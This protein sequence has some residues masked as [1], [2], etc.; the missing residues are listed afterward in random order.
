MVHDRK[1]GP[2]TSYEERKV[3]RT[4]VVYIRKMREQEA[5]MQELREIRK[6]KEK[7]L[8]KNIVDSVGPRWYQALSVPQRTALDT[9]ATAI[10]QDTL[11]GRPIRT[12][13]VMVALGLYPRPN[14]TDLMNC[15]YLGRDDPKE[16]LA[17]LFLMTYGHTID[18][19]QSLYCLNARLMLSGIFYLGLE[20]LLHLLRERF[21]A[22]P[23]KKELIRKPKSKPEPQ[24]ASPYL[25]KM[26]A[27]LYKPP[28][29]KRFQP[30][31]LPNLDDLNEPYEEEP[32]LAKPPP[33]PPP[34]PPPKKR[35]PRAYC[36]K[37]AGV[38]Q[39]D[40]H[41]SA[42]AIAK[43]SPRNSKKSRSSKKYSTVDKKGGAGGSTAQKTGR[44]KKLKAPTTGMWN[45]QYQISGVYKVRGKTVFVLGN[46]SILPPLG[47]L[48]HGGYKYMGGQCINVHCGFRGRP[49][50]PKPDP[51]DCVTKWTD[52]VFQYVKSTKCYCG[53]NFDYG[54]EGTFLPDELP[55][56]LKP[57]RNT[58]ALFNY[59]TIYEL[60]QKSLQIAKEFKALWDTDSVLHVDDG[61]DKKDKKKKKKRS[62]TTCLGQKPKP[63]DYLKCA[64]R[65]MRRV[66]IAARLPDLYLAPELKE[67]MRRRIYGPFSDR[68][69]MKLLN[70]SKMCWNYLQVLSNRGFGHVYPP[71]EPQ[72]AGHTTWVHKQRLNDKFRKYTFNYRLEMYRSH[73]KITNMMW[74]SM[75]QSQF[76]DKKFREIYF[77]YLFAKIED[78]QLMHPYTM[79]E[80]MD[81]ACVMAAKRY[82]CVPAGIEPPE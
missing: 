78:L 82:C 62:S 34:P 52:S 63:E 31:P 80:A 35:I 58:P 73:A 70:K 2:E 60:D 15:I 3:Y 42:T 7:R 40:P 81:R 67:W 55:F 79:G 26:V 72:Y 24:L 46:V 53:H 5:F 11:E 22:E 75:C 14:S 16:L 13:G 65:L 43:A 37:L 23:Q 44:R 8:M 66:N 27:C 68:Q 54:N 36:D 30:A 25:Q 64:L 76:P 19:K 12:A 32:P 49:P 51:C 47:E 50:P 71:Q 41:C 20:N 45:A 77:S 38:M 57:T 10:Y 21:K 18:G 9:L 4:Q 33:P 17:Q 69:K 61:T 56:F 74:P 28:Q 1:Y 48:I 29:K 39:I 6:K 59:Q